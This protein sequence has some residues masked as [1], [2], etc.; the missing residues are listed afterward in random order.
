VA[1]VPPPDAVAALAARLPAAPDVQW[2]GQAQWHVTLCFLGEVPDD[3]VERL[4]V[5]L[6]AVA[7][8]TPP[9]TLALRGAGRF[10]DRVLW[11]GVQ[12]EVADLRLLA[13]EVARA[14]A[15][16]GIATERRSYTP[17]LTLGYRRGGLTPL[18]RAL[19]QLEGPDWRAAEIVLFRSTPGPVYEPLGTWTLAG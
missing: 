17:H 14:A 10:G 8:R 19:E 15:H 6:A 1:V 5:C 12:G 7:S 16:V 11:A 2:A 4:S 18:L 9:I 13:A 3:R